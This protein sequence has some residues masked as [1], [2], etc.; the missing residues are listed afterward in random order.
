MRG[1]LDCSAR[2]RSSGRGRLRAV[3]HD[4][5]MDPSDLSRTLQVDPEAEFDVIRAAH[6]VLAAKHHPDVG[7]S[8]ELLSRISTAWT[9]LSDPPAPAED[10]RQRRRRG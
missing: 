3:R 2:S 8:A 7:G 9:L 5:R 1:W 4:A 10:G 6:R